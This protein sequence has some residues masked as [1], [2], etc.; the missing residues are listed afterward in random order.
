VVQDYRAQEVTTVDGNS[1]E[2]SRHI[3]APLERVWQALVDPAQAG[4]WFAAKANIDPELGGAYELF[5]RP[6]T[7]ESQSTIGCRITAIAPCRYLAFTW[8]GPDELGALMNEGDPPPPPT[9]VTITVSPSAA[10]ADLRVRH[11]GFGDGEGWSG[12]V[13][14]HHRAWTAVLDNLEALLSGRPLPRPWDD[15]DSESA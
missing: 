2:L 3:G 12:A 7:P 9:H 13:A 14:W 15:A 1:V 11:V 6:G 4:T 5:W 8:R 10:G